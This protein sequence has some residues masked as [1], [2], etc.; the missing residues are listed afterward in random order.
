MMNPFQMMGA[1]QNPIALLQE[2]VMGKFKSQNP[3]MFNQI[4][5]MV[6]GKNESQLKEMAFNIAKEKNID[7]N[8]FAGQFG[9]KL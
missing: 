5:Q 7:L 3:Q 2:Q 1:M 4:Q 8:K 9:I 6:N